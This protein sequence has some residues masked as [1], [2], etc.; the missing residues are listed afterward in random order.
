MWGVLQV[1]NRLKKLQTT[2]KDFQETKMIAIDMELLNQYTRR[3]QYYYYMVNRIKI[4][5]YIKDFDKI[6][7]VIAQYQRFVKPIDEKIL[8]LLKERKIYQ[9]KIKNA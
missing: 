2:F 5:K 6:N 7:F 1:D 9:E 8:K 3:M 4:Y